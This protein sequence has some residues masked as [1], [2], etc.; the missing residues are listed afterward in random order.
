MSGRW[1]YVSP[2]IENFMGYSA[3]SWLE[4][5]RRWFQSIHPEDCER[6][7]A[8]EERAMQGQPFSAEYRMRAR[9]GRMLW[10]RDEAVFISGDSVRKPLLQGVMLDVSAQ[11][12]FESVLVEW[13]NRYEMAVEVSGRIV[14]DW[15]LQGNVMKF[16]GGL[17]AVLGYQAEEIAGDYRKWLSLIHPEDLPA[18]QAESQRVLERQEPFHFEYRLR[19]KDGVYITIKD[20]GYFIAEKDGVLHGILGFLVDVTEQENS[21]NNFDNRKKWMPLVS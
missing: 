4:D 9:D 18:Y 19:R 16:G 7:L 10:F 3:A 1:H 8:A 11:K 6:V 5:P 20:D 15:D 17:K 13:K 14:Y 2:Q 12:Q 21:K